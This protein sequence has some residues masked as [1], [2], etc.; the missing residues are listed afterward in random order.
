MISLNA[1]IQAARSG[2]SGKAFGIIATEIQKLS[3]EI[4]ALTSDIRTALE[5]AG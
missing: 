5:M 4:K 2:E 1:L 3:G